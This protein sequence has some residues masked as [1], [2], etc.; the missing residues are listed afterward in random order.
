M[1][2]GM[3]ISKKQKKAIRERRRK[4][5][6]AGVTDV[7]KDSTQ[8]GIETQHE[9]DEEVLIE[10]SNAG[11]PDSDQTDQT[12]KNAEPE[13]TGPLA[14]ATIGRNGVVTVP[15]PDDLPTKD[16]KKFRKDVRRQARKVGIGEDKIQFGEAAKE[17]E[18]QLNKKKR[19]REFPRINDLIQ[20]EKQSLEKKAK[21]E[22]QQ[23]SESNLSDEI[24][25][26]YRAVDCEM[27]GIGKNGRISALARVSVTDWNGNVLLDTFVKVPTKVTDFRTQWSGVSA[28]H[29]KAKSAMEVE[30]CR[31]T[32]AE[33][34]KGKVLVGHALKNDLDALMLQHPKE[35]IRDTARYRPYQRLGGN[36]WRP[37][38]LR[39]LVKEH[40]DIEIQREGESH[41]SIDDARAAMDLFKVSREAWEAD[42]RRKSKRK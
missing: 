10:K 31:K 4:K 2:K 16:A 20:E 42:L 24:K 39:D 13:L 15:V 26:Q 28:K 11:L 9:S 35:D 17:S 32:V 36:K 27:V 14:N 23:K 22:A 18:N 30:E 3:F 38:K 6:L 12:S 33:L 25:D 5:K 41:D 29:I 7:S 40:C 34:L 8:L 19:K 37:R 21:L 1:G